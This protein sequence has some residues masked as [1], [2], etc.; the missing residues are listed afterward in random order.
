MCEISRIDL[1]SEKNKNAEISVPLFCILTNLTAKGSPGT[2]LQ[3]GSREDPGL[4]GHL[5]LVKT[6]VVFPKRVCIICGI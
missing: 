5:L 1:H 6:S 4:A 2:T 3:G